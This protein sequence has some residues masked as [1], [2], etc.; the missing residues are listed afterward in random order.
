VSGSRSKS[1]VGRR[2]GPGGAFERDRERQ[3]A[4]KLAGIDSILLTARRIEREPDEVGRRLR[5]HLARRRQ[6]LRRWAN[7]LT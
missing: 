6:E 4:L 7:A 5:T 2:T 3:E 1:T